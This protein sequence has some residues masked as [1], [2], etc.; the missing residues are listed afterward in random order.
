MAFWAK[1]KADV[2]TEKKDSVANSLLKKKDEKKS[3]PPKRIDNLRIAQKLQISLKSLGTGSEYHFLTK[4]LSATGMFVLCSDHKRYPF[5]VQSTLLETIIQ[6]KAG[7]DEAT[8]LRCL[9]KIARI[10]E[11]QVSGFGV[12]IVQISPEQRT[13]L[14]QFIAKH[15]SPDNFVPYSGGQKPPD[16]KNQDIPP[17]SAA[18]DSESTEIGQDAVPGQ[19]ATSA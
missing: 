3:A 11:G 10:V 12:R 15:G 4:D 7:D 18:G 8:E 17:P 2:E 13:V 1:K 16:E 9:C 6:L 14:E 19:L 5:Q